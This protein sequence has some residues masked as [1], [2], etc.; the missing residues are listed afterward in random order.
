[1]KPLGNATAWLLG[2]ILALAL[3]WS[4][5][6]V[7]HASPLLSPP[8]TQQS[9]SEATELDGSVHS[10]TQKEVPRDLHAQSRKEVRFGT[11]VLIS[12]TPE[13]G[14]MNVLTPAQ[15]D[16]SVVAYAPATDSLS[17]WDAPSRKLDNESL[18]A[19]DISYIN[20][21]LDDGKTVLIVDAYGP[22]SPQYAGTLNGVRIAN[23]IEAYRTLQA[24]PVRATC[25]G[26]SGGGIDCARVAE[27]RHARDIDLIIDSGPTDLVG[28]LASSQVQN[29]LGFAAAAG[30]VTSLSA[31]DQQRLFA[32]MR[33]SAVVGYKFLRA[34]SDV[35]P[36]GQLTT[37][38]M[39]LGGVLFPLPYTAAFRSDALDDPELQR[40]LA[41][42]SPSVRAG[43]YDATI[44]ER[45][46]SADAFVPCEVHAQ[47]FAAQSGA[48]VIT[49]HGQTAPGHAMMSPAQLLALING[50]VPTTDVK[51]Y[52]PEMTF[53]DRLTNTAVLGGM[54]AI[55]EY[56]D[57]L[58][59]Q[60]PPVLD[61]LDA[62]IVQVD[63]AIDRTT[64][65]LDQA[66]AE[67]ATVV[68]QG[69]QLLETVTTPQVDASTKNS[70]TLAGAVDDYQ[71]PYGAEIGEFITSPQVSGALDSAPLTVP[72][73]PAPGEQV[74][75]GNLDMT[76]PSIPGLTPVA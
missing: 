29:G 67:V 49:N 2:I 24:L 28:F 63:R 12:G 11:G 61:Q 41:E 9:L 3:G 17:P 42:L 37:G 39:T 53:A 43:G 13:V 45:C 36:V 50:G 75:V 72:H 56:G 31:A 44:V 54:W 65:S 32:G 47:T 40:V 38:V 57:W 68:A 58:T 23:G 19:T 18:S 70:E 71:I 64:S 55:S 48:V 14:V 15:P 8:P 51:T 6:G 21:L 52:A 30:V 33:P 4:S 5:S 35:V 25:Y 60:A 34:V 62:A 73:I 7:V 74:R 22:K 66:A 69:H 46:N 10:N 20:A 76:M 59:E 27:Y 16:D 26:F 1:M